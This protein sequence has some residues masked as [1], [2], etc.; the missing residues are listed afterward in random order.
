MKCLLQVLFPEPLL[1]HIF[2]CAITL[3]SIYCFIHVSSHC[4]LVKILHIDI[5]VSQISLVRVV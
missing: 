1:C 4:Y 2:I 5:M 3:F